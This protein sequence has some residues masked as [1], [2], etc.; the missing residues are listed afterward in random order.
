MGSIF[1]GSGR[2]SVSCMTSVCS[3]ANKKTKMMKGWARVPA[4]SIFRQ[5]E[6]HDDDERQVGNRGPVRLFLD[7][8]RENRVH[9]E[10][11]EEEKKEEE[12]ALVHACAL[13]KNPLL[14]KYCDGHQQ[15]EKQ[16]GRNYE[17]LLEEK[18]EKGRD[19]DF[20]WAVEMPALT[21]L[22]QADPPVLPIPPK[23]GSGAETRDRQHQPKARFREDSA[24]ARNHEQE[25]EE[26]D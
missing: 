22:K 5:W 21:E 11:G 16:P 19:L 12:F 6:G 2:I 14:E 24:P 8:P 9:Q 3:H 10:N 23:H 18:I 7:V 26:G 1:C 13:A 17:R 4:R 20:K 15:S 25:S